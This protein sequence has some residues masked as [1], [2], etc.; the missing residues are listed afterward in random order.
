VI[1]WL[2]RLL[3]IDLVESNLEATRQWV[4]KLDQELTDLRKKLGESVNESAD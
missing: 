2:K 3:G 1:A 4:R